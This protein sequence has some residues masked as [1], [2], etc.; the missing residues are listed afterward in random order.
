ME[1]K[2][3]KSIDALPYFAAV[4]EYKAQQLDKAETREERLWIA[5]SIVSWAD[6]TA[7]AAKEVKELVFNEEGVMNG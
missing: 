2:K 3:A 4:V 1:N 6:A 5:E 7:K